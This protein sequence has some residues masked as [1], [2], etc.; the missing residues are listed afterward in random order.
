MTRSADNLYSFITGR[1]NRGREM[2]RRTGQRS[3]GVTAI[4]I[5]AVVAVLAIL[6]GMGFLL[7]QSMRRAARVAVAESR[8]KQVGTGL[9][10]YFRKFHAYP[11]Q[12]C[13]LVAELTPFVGDVEVFSNP[14]MDEDS[15]GQTINILYK[16]PRLEDLDSPGHYV[17]A[18]IDDGL[19][20]A[21]ILETNGRVVQRSIGLLS[22]AFNDKLPSGATSDAGGEPTTVT[23]VV[24]RD[25]NNKIK[26]EGATPTPLGE[27]GAKETDQFVFTIKGGGPFVAVTTKAG[28]EEDT[29]VLP[30]FTPGYS[31]HDALGFVIEFVK[32]DGDVLTFTVTS[33]D[34][35]S[36]LSHIVFRIIGGKVVGDDGEVTITRLRHPAGE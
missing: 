6:L 7:F 24:I 12:G 33:V 11:P 32:R 36:A 5:L 26:F 2:Y 25:A 3:K 22:G 1:G 14:V 34:N 16:Q 8:L 4:E 19:Q 10:L 27:D 17:T 13:D 23:Y 28:R 15:P 20:T 35:E 31:V 9:E 30:T 29:N 18:M 21:F